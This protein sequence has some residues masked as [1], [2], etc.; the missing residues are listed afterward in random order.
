MALITLYLC[1][2]SDGLERIER[3]E[4]GKMSYGERSCKRFGNCSFNGYDNCY[5]CSVN[6][7]WYE[8]NGLVFDEVVSDAKTVGKAVQKPA[9][10]SL[11]NKTRNQRKSIKRKR[12]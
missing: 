1:R 11:S 8:N 2:M 6:C 9:I 10:K 4:G 7:E 3:D 12:K 5:N